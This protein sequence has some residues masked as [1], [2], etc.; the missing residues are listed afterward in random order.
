MYGCMYKKKNKKNKTR[1]FKPKD[2]LTLNIQKLKSV[3][4]M[5]AGEKLSIFFLFFVFLVF[6]CLQKWC[7]K[8]TKTKKIIFFLRFNFNFK[9]N[10]Y[11]CMYVRTYVSGNKIFYR[12]YDSF[13]A[14]VFANI[15]ISLSYL[16]FLAQMFLNY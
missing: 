16:K 6:F 5:N 12:A 10:M 13:S 1:N 3:P 15:F 8:K 4:L 7:C 9:K 11:V 14:G 2:R